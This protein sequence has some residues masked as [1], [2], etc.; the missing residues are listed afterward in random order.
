MT[1]D[2]TRSVKHPQAPRPGIRNADVPSETFAQGLP[3]VGE[4]ASAVHLA[5]DVPLGLQAGEDEEA[6][7][8]DTKD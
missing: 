5:R 3:D 8:P 4:G 6:A 7:L 2:P 1:D